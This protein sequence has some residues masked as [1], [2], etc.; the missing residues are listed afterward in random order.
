MDILLTVGSV[1]VALEVDGPYHFVR[2]VAGRVVR[3]NG[4]TQ[5]RDFL[6][7]HSGLKVVTVNV[8]DCSLDH[9]RSQQFQALLRDAICRAQAGTMPVSIQ[10]HQDLTRGMHP[11][12]H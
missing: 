2:G 11:A 4:A 8:V 6:L 7:Q 9:L 10:A 5:L 1:Q 3:Q 12:V